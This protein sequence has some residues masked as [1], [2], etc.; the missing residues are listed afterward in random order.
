MLSEKISRFIFVPLL[1]GCAVSFCTASARAQYEGQPGGPGNQQ[2]AAWS[3]AQI[4][5]RVMLKDAAVLPAIEQRAQES[6]GDPAFAMMMTQV[7]RSQSGF[8][9]MNRLGQP[10]FPRGMRKGMYR[11]GNYPTPPGG[12]SLQPRPNRPLWKNRRAVT[13]LEAMLGESLLGFMPQATQ[14]IRNSATLQQLEQSGNSGGSGNSGSMS[15]S[16]DIPATYAADPDSSGGSSGGSN[17]ENMEAVDEAA[18][19]GGGP[20]NAEYNGAYPEM[21]MEYEGG[22]GNS[23]R[24]NVVR[25]RFTDDQFYSTVI[26]ALVVNNTDPAWTTLADLASGQLSV[27][28]ENAIRDELLLKSVLAAKELNPEMALA[29]VAPVIDAAVVDGIQSPSWKLI[30]D[31]AASATETSLHLRQ[32][33]DLDTGMQQRRGGQPPAY[34]G[35]ME[36]MGEYYDPQATA[37]TQRPGATVEVTRPEVSAAGA[38][39]LA[40]ALWDDQFA[41]EVGQ[42]LDE[43]GN[44]SPLELVALASSLPVDRVRHSLYKLFS[45]IHA[46]GAGGMIAGGL[47]Q[48]YA[49]DPGMLPVLKTLPRQRPTRNPVP[50]DP[51]ETWNEATLQVVTTLRDRFREVEADPKLRYS[52]RQMVPLHDRE[53]LPEVALAIDVPSEGEAGAAASKTKVYYTRLTIYDRPDKPYAIRDAVDHYEKRSN[54]FRRERRE[55]RTLWFD[56]F[57]KGS[58]GTRTSIDILIQEGAY[59]GAT[60]GAPA[61]AA[62]AEPMEAMESQ[63]VGGLSGGLSGASP[64]AAAPRQN[65]GGQAPAAAQGKPYTVE[66][67]VVTVKDPKEPPATSVADAN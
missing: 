19:S 26:K 37:V 61:V 30:A 36:E 53:A 5:Q 4:M 25:E 40:G 21:E 17:P 44:A 15:G 31:L 20:A 35:S 12:A 49:S 65:F 57:R 14:A 28:I 3:D 46:A 18:M 10:G 2:S 24:A 52:G 9:E 41:S 50:G 59:Q 6:V 43:H 60:G 67:V 16:A 45:S 13:S 64:A 63:P 33:E 32:S 51:L 56:G 62:S 66:I 38:G 48:N 29:V 22:R 39:V 1:I 55:L 23:P 27:S 7:L 11:N 54:G 34:G 47:F 8:G 58:D 42:M